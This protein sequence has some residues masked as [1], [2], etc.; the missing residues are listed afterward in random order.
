MGP[1]VQVNESRY[2][3]FHTSLT[4]SI[5]EAG[6]RHLLNTK[7]TFSGDCIPQPPAPLTCSSSVSLNKS[8]DV[9]TASLRFIG[10]RNKTVCVPSKTSAKIKD[11]YPVLFIHCS[12]WEPVWMPS[13]FCQENWLLVNKLWPRFQRHSAPRTANESTRNGPWSLS[14]K[15][16][17]STTVNSHLYGSLLLLFSL[18]IKTM[19]IIYWI[20]Y[21][22][23]GVF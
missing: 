14:S 15:E 19:I 3:C 20:A 13:H 23:P 7:L 9:K 12:L 6:R 2:S 1:G 16:I 22:V 11:V 17:E 18:R 21:H 8:W 4:K 10:D 5:T